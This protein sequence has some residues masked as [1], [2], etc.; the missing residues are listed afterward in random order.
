VKSIQCSPD[1]VRGIF[2]QMPMNKVDCSAEGEDLEKIIQE[3]QCFKVMRGGEIIGAYVLKVQGNE[4]W[5]S[6]AI[7]RDK[8]DLTAAMLSM[9][10][11]NAQQFGSIGFKTKRRGL[12]RKAQRHGYE[13]AGYIM[14]KK[15][16]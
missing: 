10:D 15:L 5:V 6:A 16:K 13:I 11:F 14:R 1:D 7:G 9:I 3:G 4:V 8:D 2:Q 12:V